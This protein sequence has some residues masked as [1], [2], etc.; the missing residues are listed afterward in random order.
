MKLRGVY[1]ITDEQLLPDEQFLP[2]MQE[3]VAAG[4]QLIQYRNKSGDSALRFRQASELLALCQT[5]RI[6][7][8]IN[9]DVELC[10]MIGADGVHL[11]QSDC[12]LSQA[13]VRL[14]QE[15]II[16]ITCHQSLELAQSAQEGGADY[17][18]FGRFYPSA[19]KPG[20]PPANPAILR[21]ASNALSI[22]VVAIGGINA[23]NGGLLI[24]SGADML[25]VVGGIF[26]DRNIAE[27]I[28]TLNS[29]FTSQQEAL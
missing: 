6:P 1:A 18:A 22:P 4:V 14:G 26:A 29:L 16:G 10:A 12:T 21:E 3:T 23:E 27:N 17:V 11:G 8:I 7:L 15:A 19:T 9:D 28:K 5:R 25:A 20:A 2:A 24:A 13:R